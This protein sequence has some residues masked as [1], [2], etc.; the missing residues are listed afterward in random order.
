VDDRTPGASVQVYSMEV[1]KDQAQQA[2][3][4]DE[5]DRGGAESPLPM[6]LHEGLR[7]VRLDTDLDGTPGT[8]SPDCH[9]RSL[10]RPPNVCARRS[11][12]TDASKRYGRGCQ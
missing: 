3:T 7:D 12:R 6:R 5:R 11:P 4:R 1:S 9:H 10:L 2:C 8:S